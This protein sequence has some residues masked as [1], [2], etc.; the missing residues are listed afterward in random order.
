MKASSYLAKT[1]NT[2][3]NIITSDLN[4]AKMDEQGLIDFREALDARVVDEKTVLDW[5][6]K[7]GNVNVSCG[8][9][10]SG[11]TLNGELTFVS[12]PL[13]F[14]VM[15]RR[16]DA[17]KLLLSKAGA[18]ATARDPVS[19]LTAL[20]LA[21]L[22]DGLREGDQQPLMLP[23]LTVTALTSDSSLQ[24][25]IP[26][27]V[28]P[29]VAPKTQNK[30]PVDVTPVVPPKTQSNNLLLLGAASAAVVLVAIAAVSLV[31]TWRRKSTEQ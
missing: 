19:K 3:D 31:V 25:K 15:G 26:V 4:N 13:L 10:F 7:Y 29:V 30:T 11:T 18:D 8:F 1:T 14:C 5:C 12:L 17:V 16:T 21:K 9:Y 27:D 22:I 24:N 23:L 6:S 28:T 20:E 2:S